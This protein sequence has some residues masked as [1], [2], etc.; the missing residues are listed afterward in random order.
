MGNLPLTP[1]SATTRALF[2]PSEASDGSNAVEPPPIPAEVNMRRTR[3]VATYL[4]VPE[5]RR[6]RFMPPCSCAYP[7]GFVDVVQHMS[8]ATR[9][10]APQ[11]Q[12]VQATVS[13]EGIS[14]LTDDGWA[15]TQ[16]QTV[17]IRDCVVN[18]RNGDGQVF[19]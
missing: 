12:L 11:Y 15:A 13:E 8:C 16:S 5:A 7:P 1:A 9:A 4:S 10:C 18:S 19:L 14:H 6:E 17:E 3:N 2:A